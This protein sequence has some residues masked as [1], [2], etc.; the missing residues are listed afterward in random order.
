M[1]FLI[2]LQKFIFKF[3]IF[4]EMLYDYNLYPNSYFQK[5]QY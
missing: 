1:A 3:Y 4:T 2:Y 5:W